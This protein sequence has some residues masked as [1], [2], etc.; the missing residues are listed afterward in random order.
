MKIKTILLTSAILTL[1]LVGCGK[2]AVTPP[3]TT[4]P[5]TTPNVV[6]TASVVNTAT[7]FEKAISSKGTWIIAI[8]KD[9][10]IDSNLVVEGEYKNGKKDTAG[11]DIIKR[12]IA[13]YSQD[14]NRKVTARF[15]LT[16]PKLTFS[17]PMGSIEHG[18][19]KGDLYVSANNFQLIDAT[20]DGN[21]YFTTAEAK[22]TFKMDATS[23]VT[24]K[25]EMKK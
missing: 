7:A 17:S 9:L 2:K 3:Q 11:K 1:M 24:G 19:F 22:S 20:V 23:K 8:T 16:A 25:Q 15:I 18:T 13:L 4:P 6:T 14:E 10:A 5:E 12:K 21:V